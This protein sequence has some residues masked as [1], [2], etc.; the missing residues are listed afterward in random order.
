MKNRY[1][2]KKDREA[3][4]YRLEGISMGENLDV[5]FTMIEEVISFN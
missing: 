4:Q 2:I 5:R 1:K 3:G